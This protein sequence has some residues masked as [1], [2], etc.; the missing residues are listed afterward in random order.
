MQ[1]QSWNPWLFL[2]WDCVL[3]QVSGP[4]LVCLFSRSCVLPLQPILFEQSIRSREL[5]AAMEVADLFCLLAPFLHGECLRRVREISRWHMFPN[6][7][8]EE[9]LF[10]F[11]ESILLKLVAD[12]ERTR[13]KMVRLDERSKTVFALIRRQRDGRPAFVPPRMLG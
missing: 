5:P 10:G 1:P 9:W 8:S 4:C 3:V 12:L 13:E 2:D 6:P 7:H 11:R